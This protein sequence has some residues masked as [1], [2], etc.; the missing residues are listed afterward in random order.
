M[1]SAS[2]ISLLPILLL[3]LSAASCSWL[4]KDGTRHSLVLGIGIISTK[5]KMQG[6][7][8][9]T[10]TSLCGVTLQHNPAMTGLIVGYA[11]SL[12]TQNPPRW[13]GQ[14]SVT[15]SHTQPLMV[16]SSASNPRSHH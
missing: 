1:T 14:L 10:K 5:E 15:A 12:L 9:I 4:G 3:A 11:D 16:Q 13:E 2:Q 6:D 7:A 8:F